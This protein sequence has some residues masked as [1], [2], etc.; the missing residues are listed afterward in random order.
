LLPTSQTL[1][2]IGWRLRRISWHIP[3]THF[4]QFT[5][6]PVRKVRF[7][8]LQFYKLVYLILN[9]FSRNVCKIFSDFYY[10]FQKFF[11]LK[12]YNYFQ[13]ILLVFSIFTVFFQ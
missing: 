5:L 3:I 11:I 7:Y 2:R 10:L 13:H 8:F 12:M 6:R 1:I 9:V 4:K